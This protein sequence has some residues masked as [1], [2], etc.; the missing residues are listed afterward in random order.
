MFDQ[1]TNAV[2]KSNTILS[3]QLEVLA[4]GSM[5]IEFDN[6]QTAHQLGQPLCGRLKIYLKENFEAINVT[7]N[8]IGFCRSHFPQTSQFGDTT[9]LAKT[10]VDVE[11]TLANF[12]GGE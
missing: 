9:R 6:M 1:P 4:N 10:L 11:Y 2:K 7:L 12:H 8:L 3:P 5:M